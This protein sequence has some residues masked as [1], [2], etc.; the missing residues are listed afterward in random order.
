VNAIAFF[1]ADNGL[2]AGDTGPEDAPRTGLIWRTADAGRTWT[3]AA[4]R[5]EVFDAL[6]VAGGEVWGGTS[7]F[8]ASGGCD[9]GVWKSTDDGATWQQLS[10]TPIASLAFGDAT[11]GWA[12]MWSLAGPELGGPAGDVI[13]TAD[14]GRT[15]RMQANPCPGSIGWPVAVSFPDP[16][17]GWIG[18]TANGAS[19]NPKGVVATEDGGETWTVRSAVRIPGEGTSVG[20]I[21]FADYLI[22]LAM[23]SDGTGLWWGGRGTTQL[24][25]DGGQTWVAS[26]PGEFDAKIPSGALLLDDQQWLVAMW[27]GNAGQDVLEETRDAGQTWSTPSLPAP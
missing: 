18:C 26:P 23:L 25:R 21:D 27:D 8:G 14:G 5:V 19:T 3:I 11:H 2:I 24:T 9:P 10:T 4:P 16:L 1:D 7:C 12:T 6:A 17:H 22:G 20:T 13:S 15:W